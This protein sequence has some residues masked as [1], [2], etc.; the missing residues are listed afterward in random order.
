MSEE[1]SAGLRGPSPS[2]VVDEQDGSPSPE[3]AKPKIYVFS[4]VAE[5]REGPCYAMA[6]DGI[7]LGS[8]WCSYEGYAPRDLGVIPGSRP[9]RHQHY[10]KHYPGGYEMEFVRAAEIDNHAG[11]QDAFR[12]NELLPEDEGPD[13]GASSPSTTDSRDTPA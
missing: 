9:D 3:A 2:A 13:G 10:A 7:V 5:G 4:G 1:E 8:H 11:L 6:A 12:L